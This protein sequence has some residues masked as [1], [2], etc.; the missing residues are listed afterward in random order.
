MSEYL[1]QLKIQLISKL[2]GVRFQ[3]VNPRET[4][5]IVAGKP[6][7]RVID[8]RD[9]V[10]LVIEGKSYKYDKWYTKPEHLAETIRVFYTKTAE[11]PP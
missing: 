5:V 6:E 11:G 9:Y 7:T 3:D 2:P 10:T 1:K 4:I 8:E